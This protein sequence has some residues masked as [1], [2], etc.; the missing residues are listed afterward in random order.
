MDPATLKK[1]EEMVHKDFMIIDPYP[2]YMFPLTKKSMS[3]LSV[4]PT[5]GISPL[6]L[7]ED[8]Y[9]FLPKVPYVL[10]SPFYVSPPHFLSPSYLTS[11]PAPLASVHFL[12]Y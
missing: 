7:N 6:P 4:I 9:M 1:F 5:C 3:L 11:S 2:T 8:C 12:W 10:F